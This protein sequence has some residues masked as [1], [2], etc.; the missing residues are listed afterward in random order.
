MILRRVRYRSWG[1]HRMV[2][3]VDR[4]IKILNFIAANHMA[5]LVEISKG[6]GLNKSTTLG[7]I[8]TLEAAGCV[9]RDQSTGRY[10]LGLQLFE[11]GQAVLAKMDVRKTAMPFLTDLSRKYEETVHLA[12]LS[13]DEVIY[14]D[15][16]DSP[17]SIRIVSAIGGRNPAYCTGV[18]KVLL[19]GL[20]DGELNCLLGRMNFRPVTPN[21][22]C[23]A[24]ALSAEIE[25]VRQSG[26]A[27]DNEE[28]EEGLA[29]FAAPVRN[30][31]GA[32]IAAISISGPTTRIING[33][34]SR[35][36]EDTV[37]CADKISA[38][39]GYTSVH[40]ES[41]LFFPH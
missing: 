4:A 19:A 34:S 33:N 37:G 13:G 10:S 26:Y 3:A 22:I 28:I 8:A 7:I 23:D 9:L 20:E 15:K 29:C 35:L 41:V 21:T 17:R 11:L 30:H 36:I 27:T 5:R 12:V 14:I 6:V 32:I 16:V 2:Q 38:Q 31:L 39:L 1:S 40:P 25:K 18:G 24:K